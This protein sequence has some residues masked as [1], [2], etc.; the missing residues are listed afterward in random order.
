MDKII[1]DWFIDNC[2]LFDREIDEYYIDQAKHDLI[3]KINKKLY[4]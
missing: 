2:N 4:I 1:E 3:E